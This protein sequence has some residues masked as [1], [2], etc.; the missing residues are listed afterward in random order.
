MAASIAQPLG[1]F[2]GSKDLVTAGFIEAPAFAPRERVITKTVRPTLHQIGSDQH[3]RTQNFGGLSSSIR[4]ID[5]PTELVVYDLGPQQNTS[6]IKSR[7]WI[8][9]LVRNILTSNNMKVATPWSKLSCTSLVARPGAL[10]ITWTNQYEINSGHGHGLGHSDGQGHDNSLP[11]HLGP[12]FTQGV[13]IKKKHHS[14][15]SS[16]IISLAQFVSN[17]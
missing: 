7:R 11:T 5:S 16:Y 4:V 12:D 17:F 2:K 9:I 8:Q 3:H 6:P 1:Q 15:S 14:R 10:V 13:M